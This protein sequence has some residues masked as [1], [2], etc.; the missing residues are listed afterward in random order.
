M[1]TMA[2]CPKTRHIKWCHLHSPTRRV[3]DISGGFGSDK[4]VRY[5]AGSGRVEVLKYFIAYFR[6]TYL[7]SG[8]SRYLGYLGYTWYIGQTPNVGY[9]RNI[10]QYPIFKV[11]RY[12]VIS[13]TGSGIKKCRVAGGYR[14]PV[15]LWSSREALQLRAYQLVRLLVLQLHHHCL[16]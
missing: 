7:F 13:K 4:K 10:G 11:T 3:N 16:Y 1:F 8:I 9:S 5:W 14:L 12:L 15:G 6:V 2:H